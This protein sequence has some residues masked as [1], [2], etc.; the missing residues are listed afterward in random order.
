MKAAVCAA[1]VV[2][3]TSALAAGDAF[4]QCAVDGPYKAKGIKTSLIR[5]FA[6]CPSATFV[7]PNSQT[8]T[9]V[10][11][12][13]PPFAHSQYEFSRPG[14]CHFSFSAKLMDPCP[15]LGPSPCTITT[16]HV[17]C[18]G[19]L[20][21][22]GSTLTNTSGWVMSM[23]LR[24]TLDDPDNGDMTVIDAPVRVGLPAAVDGRFSLLADLPT[25]Q[26]TLGLSALP[27]CSQLELVHA[28][29]QD[30]DGNPFAKLGGG[31]RP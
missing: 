8:G 26:P 5:S 22:G 11:T 23:V 2:I 28:T 30:P 15:A 14:Y 17:Y 25:L 18:T 6:G 19:I 1:V 27:A 24:M 9:G 3:G 29:L 4:A 31:T 21:P 16:I 20:D 13:A 12:C 10:P 7:I